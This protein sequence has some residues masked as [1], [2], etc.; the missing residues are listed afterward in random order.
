MF[1]IGHTKPKLKALESQN[2]V[3]VFENRPAPG[4]APALLLQAAAF[5]R[6]R[7]SRKTDLEPPAADGLIRVVGATGDELTAPSAPGIAG[8]G[9][10]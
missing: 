9:A 10:I 7:R 8:A 1:L 2:V 4:R 6:A 3:A 5:G